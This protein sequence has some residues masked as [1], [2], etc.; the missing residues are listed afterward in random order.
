[1]PE[2][3]NFL[4]EKVS[5]SQGRKLAFTDSATRM[6]MGYHWPG[7]V[8]QLEN[9][10]ERAAVMTEGETIDTDAIALPGAQ[11]TP[12]GFSSSA[13][14]SNGNAVRVDLNDPDVDERERLIAA[15]EQTGWVQAKAARLLGMTPRQIAYRIQTMNIN[16]RKI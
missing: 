2:L 4:L 9:T 8:R 1:M 10:I 3:A 6:L 16:V 12:G 13:P 14:V 5:K 7:N 11:P 15:L